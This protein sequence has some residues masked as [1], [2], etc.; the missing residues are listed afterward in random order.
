MKA[1]DADSSAARRSGPTAAIRSTWNISVKPQGPRTARRPRK[2][3]QAKRGARTE[4]VG[5]K[6]DPPVAPMTPETFVRRMKSLSAC[7]FPSSQQPARTGRTRRKRRIRHD[8]PWRAAD[9]EIT[10]VVLIGQRLLSSEIKLDAVSNVGPAARKSR[11][12]GATGSLGGP[13]RSP[14]LAGPRA[15]R[16]CHGRRDCP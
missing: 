2:I 6:R 9:G 7:R 11:T 8:P 15:A 4:H 13:A 14:D 16:A 1:S 12:I 5:R 10:R 3:P